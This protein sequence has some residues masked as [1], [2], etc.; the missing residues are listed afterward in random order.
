M[1]LFWKHEILQN[2]I[3]LHQLC[4]LLDAYQREDMLFHD[5]F[6]KFLI[7]AH[8]LKQWSQ[9]TFLY[10]KGL[11]E[12]AVEMFEQSMQIFCGK[13]MLNK[14]H[15]HVILNAFLLLFLHFVKSK[16]DFDVKLSPFL[17]FTF[18]TEQFVS[19]R[20]A[21]KTGR[22]LNIINFLRV[23]H[24]FLICLIVIKNIFRFFLWIVKAWRWPI[25]AA[26]IHTFVLVR[27][28]VYA[29]MLII[30][31][32]N[33]QKAPHINDV[34]SLAHFNS[35]FGLDQLSVVLKV[36][37]RLFVNAAVKLMKLLNVVLCVVK[38][39]VNAFCSMLLRFNISVIGCF[40]KHLL[41]L[42]INSE[43]LSDHIIKLVIQKELLLI[44][45]EFVRL[46]TV[47]ENIIQEYFSFALRKQLLK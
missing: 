10:F 41:F 8:I 20:A 2:L 42:Y 9:L 22:F 47:V 17:P 33:F 21:C 45:D 36:T 43:N 40:F 44:L 37:Q 27:F 4:W 1:Y 32:A 39:L 3:L 25:Y 11:M 30:F 46:A 31:T 13:C 28:V 19:K 23:F 5:L 29:L 14:Y 18:F 12:H 26:L 38:E 15:V 7:L 24:L 35:Y 6:S 16:M 34:F